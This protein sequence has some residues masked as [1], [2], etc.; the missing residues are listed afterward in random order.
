MLAIAL[1]VYKLKITW[2]PPTAKVPPG[3]SGR[4]APVWTI[5]ASRPSLYRWTVLCTQDSARFAIDLN[6][7][8]HSHI[9]KLKVAIVPFKDR[10]I[11]RSHDVD[12]VAEHIARGPPRHKGELAK[13]D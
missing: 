2:S 13:F 12:Q 8:K 11:D 7:T 9:R 3:R 1:H 5:A 4:V 6:I 10:S